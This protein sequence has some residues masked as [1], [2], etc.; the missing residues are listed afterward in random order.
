MGVGLLAVGLQ[1]AHR[2][3]DL[4]DKSGHMSR[5]PYYGIYL[6]CSGRNLSSSWPV[7]LV[8]GNGIMKGIC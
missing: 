5:G 4:A 1:F 8:L 7:H 3:T 6:Q 2:P